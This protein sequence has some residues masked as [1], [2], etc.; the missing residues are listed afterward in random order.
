[1]LPSF[2]ALYFVRIS[3]LA[4]KPKM[5]VRFHQT[6]ALPPLPDF[7]FFLFNRNFVCLPTSL[8]S[9][10]TSH[11]HGRAQI[12]KKCKILLNLQV[13]AGSRARKTELQGESCQL[14]SLAFCRLQAAGR[15]GQGR[16]KTE[17]FK[18]HM[19]S[20]FWQ[21]VQ[22]AKG[23]GGGGGGGDRVSKLGCCFIRSCSS[24]L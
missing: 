21:L 13:A 14:A 2:E 4:T 11:F 6:L 22:F 20:D 17:N 10:P 16:A 18:W 5:N 7:T 19:W 15:R 23:E 3:F 1:M 8:K 24:K 9:F 12:N